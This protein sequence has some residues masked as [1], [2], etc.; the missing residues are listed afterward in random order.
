MGDVTSNA[1]FSSEAIFC[2]E[3]VEKFRAAKAPIADCVLKYSQVDIEPQLVAM[4]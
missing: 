1:I 4:G 2:T 3:N